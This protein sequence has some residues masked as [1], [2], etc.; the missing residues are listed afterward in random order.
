MM[1]NELGRNDIAHYAKLLNI[2]EK[3]L[4][5]LTDQQFD[6]IYFL[7]FHG[8]ITPMNAFSSLDIT[9]LS[10]RISEM[11]Q[12]GIEFDQEYESRKNRYGKTVHYMRYRR[13]A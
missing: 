1:K 8:S 11:K 7:H 6:I 3:Q 10:T 9:K 2:T 12:I 5:M 4:E 13:A